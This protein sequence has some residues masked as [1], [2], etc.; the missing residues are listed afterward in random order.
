MNLERTRFTALDR[1]GREGRRHD[2]PGAERRPSPGAG[3]AGGCFS[4]DLGRWVPFAPLGGA[5]GWQGKYN[6]AVALGGASREKIGW[7]RHPHR[8]RDRHRNPPG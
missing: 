2:R 4:G 8:D 3:S 6:T 1:R 7:L 5:A